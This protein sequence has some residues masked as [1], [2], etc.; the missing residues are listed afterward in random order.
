VQVTACDPAAVNISQKKR[1]FTSSLVNSCHRL[2][3]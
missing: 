2:S 1:D 3:I